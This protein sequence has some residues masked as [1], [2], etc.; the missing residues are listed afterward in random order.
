MP[1]RVFKTNYDNEHHNSNTIELRKF[2]LNGWT[3]MVELVFLKHA[4]LCHAFSLSWVSCSSTFL[5]CTVWLWSYHLCSF[6]IGVWHFSSLLTA[7]WL[8]VLSSTSKVV[9]S[10]AVFC[11]SHLHL[12][13]FHIYLCSLR[14]FLHNTEAPL[15]TTTSNG[16]RD[17]H[18]LLLQSSS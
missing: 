6:S 11:P 2:D 3:W 17:W 13:F 4:F 1:T 18:Q 10:S 16:W 8:T 9:P 5:C 12:N 7:A 14:L 15:T